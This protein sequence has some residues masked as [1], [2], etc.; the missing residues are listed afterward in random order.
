M[1]TKDEQGKGFGGT[2]AGLRLVPSDPPGAPLNQPA[3]TGSPAK[4]YEA[5]PTVEHRVPREIGEAF[6]EALDGVID[7]IMAMKPTKKEVLDFESAV[8]LAFWAV[9]G[10]HYPPE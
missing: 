3:Y 9:A 6:T 7:A 5:A 2:A 8:W 10:A 4:N 1:T